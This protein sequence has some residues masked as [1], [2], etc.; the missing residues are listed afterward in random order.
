MSTL[1]LKTDGDYFIIASKGGD[2]TETNYSIFYSAVHSDICYDA[3]NI[4][5]GICAGT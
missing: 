5:G 3:G 1:W 2:S 4:G